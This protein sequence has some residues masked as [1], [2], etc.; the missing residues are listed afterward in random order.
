DTEGS[1]KSGYK[2]VNK[3]NEEQA[4]YQGQAVSQHYST[5]CF[6]WPD[7][8]PCAIQT[9]SDKKLFTDELKA[10]W[11]FHS[12]LNLCLF[13]RSST[14]RDDRLQREEDKRFSE[15][16]RWM[17]FVPLAWVLTGRQNKPRWN[18]VCKQACEYRHETHKLPPRPDEYASAGIRASRPSHDQR[19]SQ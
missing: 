8:R 18:R 19:H 14:V 1:R 10:V 12:L 13:S 3:Y 5:N 9:C 15:E 11:R 6:S 4:R 16:R 7:T 2:V 17:L